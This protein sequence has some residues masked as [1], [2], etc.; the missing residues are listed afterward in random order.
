MNKSLLSVAPPLSRV[1]EG[2]D[3][4]TQAQCNKKTQPLVPKKS[5]ALRTNS[6]R[7]SSVPLPGLGGCTGHCPQS[8]S[9]LGFRKAEDQS[10]L[11]RLLQ[12]RGL[13]ELETTV[14]SKHQ[15]AKRNVDQDDTEVVTER[16]RGWG[17]NLGG[18]DKIPRQER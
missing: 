7:I 10:S 8:W 14:R 12:V 9:A 4:H 17:E 1:K 11:F 16:Q 15:G 6:G 3:L 18:R 2:H 13:V 5:L